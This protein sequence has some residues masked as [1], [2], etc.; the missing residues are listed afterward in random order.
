MRKAWIV[1]LL[2][3]YSVSASAQRL[4]EGM[5]TIMGFFFSPLL[6]SIAIVGV[7]CAGFFMLMGKS[8]ASRQL[9]ITVFLLSMW[10]PVMKMFASMLGV[11]PP[12]DSPNTESKPGVLAEFW[13]WIGSHAGIL[14][15]VVGICGLAGF[16][17]KRRMAKMGAKRRVKIE[18]VLLLEIIERV[19]VLLAYWNNS[20]PERGDGSKRYAAST[21]EKLKQAQDE[22]LKM[23]EQVHAGQPLS[24]EQRTNLGKLINIINACMKDEIGTPVKVVVRLNDMNEAEPAET[25][26]HEGNP[27]TRI[28]SNTLKQTAKSSATTDTSPSLTDF[29]LNPLNPLSPISPWS[30]WSNDRE[31]SNQHR[32]EDSS[33]RDQDRDTSSPSRRTDETPGNFS[34]SRYDSPSGGDSGGS[35]SSSTNNSGSEI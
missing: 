11:E 13:D 19:D 31:H 35:S 4:D 28:T 25:Q 17:L 26:T 34:D 3:I 21:I 22:V 7:I 8:N 14:V 12:T 23:L 30:M 5:K 32:Q 16:V 24:D 15:L 27:T 2:F 20:K 18:L 29:L 10:I 6:T 9:G 1:L 33:S